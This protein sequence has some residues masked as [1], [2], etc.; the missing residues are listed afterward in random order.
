[1]RVQRGAAAPRRA[2]V[3]THRDLDGSPATLLADGR[4]ARRPLRRQSG[5]LRRPA[6]RRGRADRRAAARPVARGP[7]RGR[8]AARPDL[9]AGRERGH[10]LHG[11]A[12][13]GSA[14]SPPWSDRRRGRQARCRRHP[15]SRGQARARADRAPPIASA[16]RAS[17]RSARNMAA[18]STRS[19][20]PTMLETVAARDRHDPGPARLRQRRL[21]CQPA[22]RSSPARAAAQVAHRDRAV[23]HQMG[24]RGRGPAD[25]D[26]CRMGCR[27][28]ACCRNSSKGRGLG[29]CGTRAD[30]A[31]T[32]RAS[33]SSRRSE[34]GECRGSLDY[35]T[36]W[37][38]R[39]G[40][41]RWHAQGAKRGR[42]R[43]RR[44]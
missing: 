29:D 18:R 26:Q 17:R 7:G 42:P 14:R 44:G 10:A 2:P 37:R 34:M 32:A 4:A 41:G 23:R 43:P 6:S 22:S 9:A 20:D 15:A 11:R 1:M 36:T 21:Q 3:I 33:G 25:P 38:A 5:R 40:R 35:I 27:T 39:G 12:Q 24:D 30:Y 31:G 13:R 19:A 8:R 16:R 28:A